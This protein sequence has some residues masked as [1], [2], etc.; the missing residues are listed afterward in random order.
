MASQRGQWPIVQAYSYTVFKKRGHVR[1][2]CIGFFLRLIQPYGQSQAIVSKRFSTPAGTGCLLNLPH[3]LLERSC[4]GRQHHQ[5]SSEQKHELQAPCNQES[6][7][8]EGD[9]GYSEGG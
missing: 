1:S 3:W 6:R 8:G 7:N 5:S 9:G 2:V 4:D